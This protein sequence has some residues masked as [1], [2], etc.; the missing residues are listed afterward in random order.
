MAVLVSVIV[1]QRSTES[2]FSRSSGVFLQSLQLPGGSDESPTWRL[3]VTEVTILENS[4]VQ[5]RLFKTK[6]NDFFHSGSGLL[7]SAR[8]LKNFEL[9]QLMENIKL[10]LSSLSEAVTV[11]NSNAVTALSVTLN[12]TVPG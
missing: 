5:A 12:V 8:F 4:L 6:T 9:S 10:G 7:I 11:V 1:R 3:A 2:N